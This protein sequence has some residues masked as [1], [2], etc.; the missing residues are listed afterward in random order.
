MHTDTLDSITI[1]TRELCQSI[2]DDSSFQ[3]IQK[4]IGSFLADQNAQQQY[5]GVSEMGAALQQKHSSGE[6]IDDSEIAT[7][8]ARRDALV[9]NP[10]VSGFMDAQR[11]M[12]RVQQT[13]MQYV[14]KTYELGRI[15]E[16]EDFEAEEG[17]CGGGGGGGCGCH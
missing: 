1:K 14:G 3:E 12:N 5:Q 6:H 2:L 7:F 9:A 16:L 10:V 13:I 8:E 11:E 17:C 15:P 4:N